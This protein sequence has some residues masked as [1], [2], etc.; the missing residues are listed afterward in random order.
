MDNDMQKQ[1]QRRLLQ[2]SSRTIRIIVFVFFVVAGLLYYIGSCYYDGYDTSDVF[3]VVPHYFESRNETEKLCCPRVFIYD[4]MDIERRASSIT[5][6]KMLLSEI[7]LLNG[8]ADWYKASYTL[9]N[10]SIAFEDRIKILSEVLRD[11]PRHHYNKINSTADSKAFT[12]ISKDYINIMLLRLALSKCVTTDPSEAELFIVPTSVHT[13]RKYEG[14]RKD[15]NTDW[16]NLFRTLTDYQ[17]LFEHFSC[18]TAS[19]HVIFSRSYGHTKSSEG[20]WTE[21]HRDSRVKYMQRVALGPTETLLEQGYWFT[22][23]LPLL[24]LGAKH[25]RDSYANSFYIESTVHNVHSI[26]FTSL[27]SYPESVLH[28]LNHRNRTIFLSSNHAIDHGQQVDLKELLNA[29]CD[30]SNLC[31]NGYRESTVTN[32]FSAANMMELK[33]NS[34]F[35]L[36][37][38]G[39][40]P[41]R[42]SIVQDVLLGCIPVF[43]SSEQLTLWHASWGSW[44]KEA[45]VLVDAKTFINKKQNI[46]EQLMSIPP[47]E[48]YRKQM[49]IHHNAKR[50]VYLHMDDYMHDGNNLKHSC[51]VDAANL[52]LAELKDSSVKKT[53]TQ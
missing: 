2:V 10:N 23:F 18:E 3:E 19:K 9:G 32:K 24:R 44:V 5:G 29:Q 45:S 48:V 42:Q 33:S 20:L 16:E 34:V 38:R 28:D 17:R 11:V 13:S 49:L 36:E 6:K 51:T 8:Y 1:K 35:C 26:P 22:L 50:F 52:A 39:D 15:V 30:A 31:E 12:A 21:W 53:C 25:F 37:P 47:E 27:I 7:D 14:L 4:P 43:F 41:T 40:W 46:V